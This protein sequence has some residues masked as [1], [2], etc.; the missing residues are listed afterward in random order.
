MQ[1]RGSLNLQKV[2]NIFERKTHQKLIMYHFTSHQHHWRMKKLP[3]L[4]PFLQFIPSKIDLSSA[5]QE[6]LKARLNFQ[7]TPFIFD[8]LKL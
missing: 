5:Q 1:L 4:G 3:S 2:L 6:T 8:P 7:E